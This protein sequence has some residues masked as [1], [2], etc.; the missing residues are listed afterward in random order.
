MELLHENVQK[1]PSKYALFEGP[2]IRTFPPSDNAP[3]HNFSIM[4]FFSSG[5]KNISGDGFSHKNIFGTQWP[6]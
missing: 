3:E 2:K 6:L 5:K 1:L 4:G